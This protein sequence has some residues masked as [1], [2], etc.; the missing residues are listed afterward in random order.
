MVAINNLE[1]TN[2]VESWIL[3]IDG[4]CTSKGSGLGIVL[5][6]P[7]NDMI[8]RAIRCNFK[9]TN[10]EAEYEAFLVVLNLAKDLGV[11]SLI[12][13]SDSQLIVNQSGGDFQTRDSRM[14]EYMDLAKEFIL[15]FEHVKVDRISRED[16]THAD[17]LA[18]LGSAVETSF[19][20]SL[21][22][23]VA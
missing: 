5:T 12:V 14:G 6:S 2:G 21:P 23:L 1:T 15:T 16:N 7:E 17:A 22:L 4:S 18:N 11:L 3:C 19:A 10:N 20:R 9:T 8:E 13:K